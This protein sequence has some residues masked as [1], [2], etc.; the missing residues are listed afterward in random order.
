MPSWLAT[1]AAWSW[2]LLLLADRHLPDRARARHPLHRGRAVHRGTAA[3]RPAAAADVPVAPRRAA[4][5][6]PRPGCTLLIAA[7]VARRPGHAGRQPGRAPTTRRCWPRPSTL[8]RRSSR[9]WPGRPSTSRTANV[10]KYLNNIPSYLSKHKTLV[11]GTVVTGG[12]IASEFFGGLVLM[13]F[14]TFFLIKDG[15]RIWNWLLGAVRTEHG[16]PGGPGR[17]RLLAGTWCTTCEA[18]SRWPLSTPW[19]SAWPCGS[20][21]SR[22]PCRWPCWCS[23]PPSSRWW[24]CWWRARWPSW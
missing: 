8:S 9:G 10:Q 20:W 5:Y 4:Q 15:E 23:W 11:E 12:K 2:R 1:G 17:A 6:W 21:A 7:I 3:H 16:A 19:W 13:L 18:Q 24:G 14:V 22:W